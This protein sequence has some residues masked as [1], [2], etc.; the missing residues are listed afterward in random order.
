MGRYYHGDIEG[1]FWFALQSS[2]SASRFGGETYEPSVIN[3]HFGEEHLAEV[4]EEIKNIEDKLGS[5]YFVIV[6]FFEENNGYNSKMLLEAEISEAELSDYADL[7]L[8]R[9][10]RDSIEENGQCDFEAEL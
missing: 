7:L 2:D 1:K 4:L 6:K 8:G 10:I 5:K 3:Y 9:Q